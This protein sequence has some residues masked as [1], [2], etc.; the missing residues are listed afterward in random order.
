M[1]IKQEEL[2][3]DNWIDGVIEGMAEE[4]GEWEDEAEIEA[5]AV[6]INPQKTRSEMLIASGII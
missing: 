5:E 6:C 3:I 1:K 2:A 4:D